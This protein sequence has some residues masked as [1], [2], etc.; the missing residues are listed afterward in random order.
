MAVCV[1]LEIRPDPADHGFDE[2][3]MKVV[4]GDRPTSEGAAQPMKL[5]DGAGMNPDL[6]ACVQQ[7]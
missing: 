6:N 4:P 3:A 5:A 2:P 1:A 7:P